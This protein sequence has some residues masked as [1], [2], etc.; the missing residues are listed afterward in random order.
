MAF[1]EDV[2]VA[3]PRRGKVSAASGS[4]ATNS[5][6]S[7][8]RTDGKARARAARSGTNDNEPFGLHEA[9][10]HVGEAVDSRAL[11]VRDQQDAVGNDNQADSAARI[12]DPA[13]V[14]RVDRPEDLT[15]ITREGVNLAYVAREMPACVADFFD[16]LEGE[17]AAPQTRIVATHQARDA[18]A[19]FVATSWPEPTLGRQHFVQDLAL[20]TETFA[21]I[22][23]ARRVRIRID[24]NPGFRDH[25]FHAD[26][27]R[28]RLVTGYRGTGAEWL[29]NAAVERDDFDEKALSLFG[30]DEREARCLGRF[31]VGMM[32]GESW[33]GNKGN[34]L[35][36]RPCP[37]GADSDAIIVTLDEED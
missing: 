3:R 17:A 24:R 35:V 25:Q 14:L 23:R 16:G 37:S 29:P 32:K 27:T 28:L 31:W 34:G 22:T 5:E 19:R 30:A 8:K 1:V 36:R 12:A 4:R 11:R 26:P 15:A 6:K 20:L 13:H 2:A 10:G 21:R 18:I 7:I 9:V 33:P